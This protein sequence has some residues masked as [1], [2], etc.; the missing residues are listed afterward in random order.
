MVKGRLPR[1]IKIGYITCRIK[2]KTKKW[3]ERNKA[4]GQLKVNTTR[5][6]KI[7]YDKTQ[8]TEEMQNTILHELL[9][10]ICY[11]FGLKHL[12]DK[13]EERIVD[14]MANGLS[15]VL[16]DNSRF[17]DWVYCSYRNKHVK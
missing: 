13:Q 4:L 2:P 17:L 9:H 1:S 8:D 14:A 15:T 3:G 11:V 5:A 16:R 7:E 10:S 6:S 12:S